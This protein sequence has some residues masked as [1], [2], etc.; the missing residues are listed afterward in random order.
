[1]K[2]PSAPI[3]LFTY[4]RPDHFRQ[5]WD[6]LS[7]NIGFDRTK[8]FVFSDGP[9][10]AAD[11]AGVSRVRSMLQ[12]LG[13]AGTEVIEHST[14]LGTGRS[15]RTGID[16]VLEN[17]DRVIVVEDDV[18]TSPHFLAYV[19][20]GLSRYEAETSVHAI[21]GFMYA[22]ELDKAGRPDA[23]FCP[24]FPC[25]GWGTWRRTWRAFGESEP[26]VRAA[27]RQSRD[28][29]R[30][31]DLGGHYPNYFALRRA[32]Q[33]GI[34]A[35]DVWFYLSMLSSDG[36]TLVPLRSL[37]RNIGTDGSGVHAK[38]LRRSVADGVDEFRSPPVRS[39]PEHVEVDESVVRAMVDRIETVHPRWYRWLSRWS[40]LLPWRDE[41]MRI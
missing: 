37:T 17:H 30:R 10:T 28:F 1:M 32:T 36:V 7:K 22:I 2:N 12:G 16:R 4:N 33:R 34:D 18:V 23:A 41:G 35:W 29:R 20:E 5:V 31:V 6:A 39:F 40:R 9:K 11:R 3:A 21:S 24:L 13:R 38:R 14:N 25:W 26:R 15:I 8:I 19:N 27:L